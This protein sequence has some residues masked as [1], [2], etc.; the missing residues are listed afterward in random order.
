MKDIIDFPKVPSEIILAAISIENWFRENSHEEWEFMGISS[1]NK[2][3]GPF[4]NI[5]RDKII[6][7]KESML[8]FLL[9]K[10]VIKLDSSNYPIIFLVEDVAKNAKFSISTDQIPVI[11]EKYMS[12][13]MVGVI[14][15]LWTNN[16]IYEKRAN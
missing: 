15:Y 4:Y 16:S 3:F 5:E 13:K 12:D 6:P 9:E 1:R 14:N 8:A 11:F 7:N 2:G 10:K